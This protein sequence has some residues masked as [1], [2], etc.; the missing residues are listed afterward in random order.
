M[1]VQIKKKKSFFVFIYCTLV[2]LIVVFLFIVVP[3]KPNL[4][5][6]KLSPDSLI[7]S[8]NYSAQRTS[9][10]HTPAPQWPTTT[11]AFE[12]KNDCV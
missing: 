1:V 7:T 6:S 4:K 3:T 9:S 10:S 8:N 12:I 5:K 11:E 2:I